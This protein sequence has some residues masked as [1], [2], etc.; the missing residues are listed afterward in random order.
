[1]TDAFPAL[2]KSRP[3]CPGPR[4]RRR[5]SAR[6]AREP[7]RALGTAS[8][9]CCSPRTASATSASGSR[10]SRS[11]PRW[12]TSPTSPGCGSGSCSSPRSSRCCSFAPLAGVVADRFDRKHVLIVSIA[13]SS[14]RR[15]RPGGG[16]AS[17]DVETPGVLVALGV[18]LGTLFAF[19]APAQP[20]ATAN[21]VPSEDL[22]QRDL[23]AVRRQQP[24]PHRR[25][26]A[27]RADP[28]GLGARDGPSP[29]TPVTNLV[30]MV[31]LAA[32]DPPHQPTRRHGAPAAP[33]QRWSRA[34]GTRAS[35]RR[36]S[37]RW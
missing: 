27:R 12:P 3:G 28:R 32:P 7:F 10:T 5:R 16:R 33:G 17:R 21:A 30:L 23:G 18:L 26:R 8:S 20:A 4:R 19:M 13:S 36:R 25:S 34:C 2:P 24:L 11:S 9:A 31:L 35:G 22:A 1:M 37:S 15:G 6:V 29:S 14:A